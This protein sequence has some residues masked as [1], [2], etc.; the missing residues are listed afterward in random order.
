MERGI[1]V[2]T[3]KGEF[4]IVLGMR[5]EKLRIWVVSSYKSLYV[6]PYTVKKI[7]LIIKE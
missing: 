7:S 1:L 5:G 2:R 4:G 3:S 6:N